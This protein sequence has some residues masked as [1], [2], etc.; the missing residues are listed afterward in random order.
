M[1]HDIPRLRRYVVFS[2]VMSLIMV[3]PQIQGGVTGN[4]FT[5]SRDRSFLVTIENISVDSGGIDQWGYL[6]YGILNRSTGIT[7]VLMNNKI[8]APIEN[9]KL[10][11][12]IYW[13][14]GIG[15]DTQRIM[16]KD[17]KSV[18]IPGG[19]GTFSAPQVFNWTPR[20]AGTYLI[21]VSVNVPGDT[22]PF[23]DMAYI[24]GDI[25]EQ[26]DGSRYSTGVWVGADYW[27]CSGMDGWRS[28]TIGGIPDMGWHVSN[29]P[30]SK[31]QSS[32]HTTDGVFWMGNESTG[33]APKSG[34]YSLIS[35]WMD[36]SIF[37]PDPTNPSLEGEGPKIYF[38]YKYRGN[39]SATGPAGKGGLKH[40]I[41]TMDGSWETM[42]DRYERP[43]F[44]NDNLS[45]IADPI[46]NYPSREISSITSGPLPGIDLGDYQGEKIRIKISYI[47]SGKEEVGYMLDDFSLV[48]LQR[49]EID[50]F[51]I[52]NH[53]TEE[54]KVVPGDTVSFDLEILRG[55][56][57]A[58]VGIRIACVDTSPGIDINRDVSIEPGVFSINEENDREMVSIRI[59]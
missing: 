3:I 17:S 45:D 16:H 15:F 46:W 21:N 54:K 13:H 48:G 40:E 7:V 8:E 53:T 1:L 12:T 47:P 30:M 36:L 34:I 55:D 32:Q 23:S 37:D 26:G 29:H 20:Y 22:H 24:Q 43:I 10:N 33:F 11:M 49:I 52:G 39:I 59:N 9:V 28:E 2:L 5:R 25:L 56:V 57:A 38:L 35:P 6:N 19:I 42:S 58:D 31:N 51:I 50:P 14:G 4:D 44:I 27:T 18:F 41:R